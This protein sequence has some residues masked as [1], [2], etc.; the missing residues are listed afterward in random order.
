ML[1]L[2]RAYFGKINNKP[3][4]GEVSM[5][6]FLFLV[7]VSLMAMSKSVFS[8]EISMGECNDTV[9]EFN[10]SLPMQ[11]DNI[12]TWT[13]TSCVALGNDEIGLVYE[14]EVKAG[15]E[16][17]QN[18]LDSV[19]PSLIMSWCFGPTLGPLISVVD[20]VQYLYFFENG[21]SI[22]ELKFSFQD[23]ILSP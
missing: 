23:C 1:W 17:T 13:N 12:T 7:F 10:S 22:G 8:T 20:Q 19:R 14:N 18:E 3:S 15:N 21:T 6:N 5:R 9:T 11:L 2:A 16:I 4:Q